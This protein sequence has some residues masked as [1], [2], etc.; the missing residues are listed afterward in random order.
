MSRNRVD[1]RQNRGLHRRLSAQAADNAALQIERLGEDLGIPLPLL[2]EEP[3]GESGFGLG[4]L[5]AVA[6]LF[7]AAGLLN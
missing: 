4:E 5:L 7:A 1:K 6:G 2:D 3:V